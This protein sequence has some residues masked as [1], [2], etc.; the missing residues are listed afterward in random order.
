[1]E[2]KNSIDRCNRLIAEYM[3]VSVYPD[4]KK[5]SGK[6]CNYEVSMLLYEVSWDW[7]K[8]VVDKIVKDVIRNSYDFSSDKTGKASYIMEIRLQCSI[9]EAY[10]A[11]IYFIKWW[12]KNHRVNF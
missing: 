8:P 9:R 4:I 3:N 1:M 7:L 5:A 12:N 2:G 10:K 6:R 11:V